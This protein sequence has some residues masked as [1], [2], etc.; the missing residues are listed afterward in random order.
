MNYAEIKYCDIANGIG[1]RTTLFVSGCTRHCKDCFNEKTWDFNYGEI[2]TK[3]VEDKIIDSLKPNY[4]DGL[5]VLGGEPFEPKNQKDVLHLLKR[6][7]D[8]LPDK[9]IWAFTGNVL[10]PDVLDANGRGHTEYTEDI[11]RLLDVL[12]DGPFIAERKDISLKFRG[13][14]N[15]RLIDMK[16]TIAANK[17]IL[18]E[19]KTGTRGM[20]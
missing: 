2:F 14:D 5:T 19:D 15:Q 3:E 17:I 20:G 6:V 12:V 10:E 9:T 7:H 18:W 13:S 11:L 8:E 4:I 16:K 1:V